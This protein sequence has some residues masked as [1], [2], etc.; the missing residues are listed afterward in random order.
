MDER[1]EVLR[2][3]V[4]SWLRAT[5]RLAAAGQESTE[6]PDVY[7]VVLELAEEVGLARLRMQRALIELGW[8]PPASVRELPRS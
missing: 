4:R 8:A 6:D 2:D 5:D 3:A 7:A 1:D